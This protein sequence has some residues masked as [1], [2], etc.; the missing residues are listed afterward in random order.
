MPDLRIGESTFLLERFRQYQA[1]KLVQ[2]EQEAKL[3]RDVLD[4]PTK[5]RL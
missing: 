4:K 2:R 3:I 5:K 1:A